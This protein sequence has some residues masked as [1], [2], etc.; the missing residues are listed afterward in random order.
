MH[1]A[2]LR[3]EY[4]SFGHSRAAA[5]LVFDAVQRRDPRRGQAGEV[6]GTEISGW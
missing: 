5:E 1:G 2:A 6:S 4:G 3:P